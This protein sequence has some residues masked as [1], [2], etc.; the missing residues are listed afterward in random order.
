MTQQHAEP[1]GRLSPHD[2]KSR[3]DAGDLTVVDVREQWEYARDHIPGATLVP[4]GQIISRPQDVIV[5][6]NLL[7]VC[8]VGQRSGVAAE[9]AAALGKTSVFNLEG[10]MQAWRNAGL[11][12]EA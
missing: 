5:G 8:E 11:A 12:T 1:F 3:V 10:G 7:F 2:A 9:L 6:D 4:L